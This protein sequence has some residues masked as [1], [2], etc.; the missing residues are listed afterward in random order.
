MCQQGLERVLAKQS[1][2]AFQNGDWLY[3]LVICSSEEEDLLGSLGVRT[4]NPAQDDTYTWAK[5]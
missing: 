4:P 2:V 5:W 3:D 1:C